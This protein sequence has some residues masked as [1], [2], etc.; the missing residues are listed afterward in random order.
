MKLY[1]AYGRLG[2]QLFQYMFLKTIS[3]ND[4]KVFVLGFDDIKEV[5]KLNEITCFK[6]ST[7]LRRRIIARVVE[8]TLELLSKTG[9]VSSIRVDTEVV[10]DVHERE[11]TTYTLKKG[12]FSG[13]TFVGKG[14]FQSEEF[15]DKK[16]VSD[17]I[18]RESFV[19]QAK[20]FLDCIPANAH[21]IFVHVRRGDYRNMS[22]LGHSICLPLSFYKKHI[23]YFLENEK[24]PYFVILSDDKDLAEKEFGFLENK[25]F[26]I[27]NHY[28][29]DFA[30]MTQCQSAI[31]SPS[32]FGWWGAYLMKGNGTVFCPEYWMGFNSKVECQ[33][34]ST[35]KH[36]TASKVIN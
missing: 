33:K 12:L 16:L 2:N 31:L 17:L 7:W 9:I 26:S 29:V 21:R 14:F 24:N 27:D 5:I 11:S 34:S 8:P 6:K 3:D 15:F 36:F 13:I 28:G 10:L 22:V 25:L 1:I 35:P 23:D 32:S 30:I 4:E 19:N 20:D 18:I